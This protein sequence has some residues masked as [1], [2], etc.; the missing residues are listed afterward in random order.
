MTEEKRIF[1][2]WWTDDGGKTN[3]VVNY[4]LDDATRITREAAEILLK[5]AGY[6]M[7]RQT[8]FK[9]V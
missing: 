5:K 8:P 1:E 3:V 4:E 9:N 7:V 6:E 2:Q